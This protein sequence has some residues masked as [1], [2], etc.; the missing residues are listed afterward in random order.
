MSLDDNFFSENEESQ[1][2]IFSSDG[3]SVVFGPGEASD[4]T[5]PFTDM[6]AMT[7]SGITIDGMVDTVS[8]SCAYPKISAKHVNV[9][10]FALKKGP[11]F[12]VADTTIH[13]IGAP[14]KER[15]MRIL[16]ELSSIFPRSLNVNLR[17]WVS[18]SDGE[19]Q[20]LKPI[21]YNPVDN[22]FFEHTES[23]DGYDGVEHTVFVL[24]YCD[25]AVQDTTKAFSSLVASGQVSPPAD[26]II[27]PLADYLLDPTASKCSEIPASLRSPLVEV[28]VNG[29]SYRV[30]FTVSL[31]ETISAD[32]LL[33]KG[34]R[35][36]SLAHWNG[37]GLKGILLNIS[38]VA[39]LIVGFFLA[40]W[41]F[42]F[43]A[44]KGIQFLMDPKWPFSASGGEASDYQPIATYQTIAWCR[45]SS[46]SP[47]VT[48][49]S[50]LSVGLPAETSFLD[51]FIEKARKVTDVAVSA[52]NVATISVAV[53]L[54]T[55]YEY[56]SDQLQTFWAYM[57]HLESRAKGSE[58]VRK[59]KQ[60]QVQAQSVSFT[61]TYDSE[62]YTGHMFYPRP[63]PSC[64][65]IDVSLLDVFEAHANPA[66]S[67]VQNS[68]YDFASFSSERVRQAYKVIA[69]KFE[70]LTH[71]KHAWRDDALFKLRSAQRAISYN[72]DR[73]YRQF[74]HHMQRAGRSIS[75]TAGRDWSR[76]SAWVREK[77]RKTQLF[78]KANKWVRDKY[79]KRGN[80]RKASEA[81][82]KQAQAGFD[83]IKG[84][85]STRKFPKR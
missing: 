67:A 83:W 55:V 15:A 33:R 36:L 50:N 58:K 20:S 82:Y 7:L 56:L 72:V 49:S 42:H 48:R 59:Y 23:K 38:I 9:V 64:P 26:S 85:V 14:T 4:I 73:S 12:K 61:A 63:T 6:P 27:L 18:V 84:K 37:I 22:T 68:V 40:V 54:H 35:V 16:D 43:L 32:Q 24:Y 77:H 25:D 34:G 3:Y 47:V 52:T 79:G 8:K 76:A 70:W 39:S 81:G 10:N 11:L 5:M 78:S 75:H 17:W 71:P 2:D 19:T 69:P 29:R 60:K 1:S 62:V 57:K 21:G 28:E 31:L 80:V 45:A 30:P 66:V 74:M 13:L 53:A 41:G 46:L 65:N 51:I 44:F